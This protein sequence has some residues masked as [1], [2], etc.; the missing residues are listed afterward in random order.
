[1]T[2][3]RRKFTVSALSALAAFV[4]TAAGGGCGQNEGGSGTTA[5]KGG[6]SGPVEVR[7]AY[8]P[9]ITHAP[10]IVGVADGTFQKA[11]EGS[12]TVKP[13][14][15]LNGPKE[16]EA[17]LAREVDIAYVG[18]SPA[19]NAFLKSEGALKVVSG[20]A[21]GGAV[22][23]ARDGAGIAKME[24]LAGKRIGTPQK[25]GTQDIAARF[26]IT[27]TLGQ[28]LSE[29]GGT[30]QIVAADSPELA[31]LFQQNQL[32]AAWMQEPWGARLIKEQN[33]KLI[34]DE[35]DAWPNKAYATTVVVARTAF[36]QEHPDLVKKLVAA[37][38]DLCKRVDTDKAKAAVTVGD[39]IKRLTKRALA[40]EVITA[41]LGRI[42][43][44]YEPYADTLK[45]QADRAFALGFLGRK[46]PDLSGL[47]DITALNEALA[48]SQQK[49]VA[50]AL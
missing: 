27:Q 49:P 20:A 7:L 30:T 15:F 17:L 47:L 48:A 4:L 31:T 16:M 8:F 35:R 38:V 18:V 28:K 43:F 12:A 6:A 19:I 1:M 40:P 45:T 22:L 33:A 5:G 24:D 23:V 32:D 36:L 14:V 46:Q 50:S 25:G 11:V 41:S 13:L 29:Q 44:T 3:T 42:D 37:H 39:E 34:L 10:A 9:N 21:S 26:Y 2:T